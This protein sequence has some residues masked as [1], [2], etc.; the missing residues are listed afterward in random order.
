MASVRVLRYRPRTGRVPGERTTK[1][2]VNMQTTPIK[3]RDLFDVVS[4]PSPHLTDLNIAE[5][6]HLKP[7]TVHAALQRLADEAGI[8][9]KAADHLDGSATW[10]LPGSSDAMLLRAIGQKFDLS[11]RLVE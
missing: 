8:V 2:T 5:L 7:E 11:Q 3:Y 4:Q 1:A 10:V 6:L 9:M